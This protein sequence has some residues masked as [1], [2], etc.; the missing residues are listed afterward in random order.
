[1]S[2]WHFILSEPTSSAAVLATSSSSTTAAAANNNSSQGV[3]QRRTK[4]FRSNSTQ[5][6][7]ASEA[8]TTTTVA[9]IS[10]ASDTFYDPKKLKKFLY[11]PYLIYKCQICSRKMNSFNI[12]HWLQHDRENH[13]ALLNKESDK[14]FVYQQITVNPASVD[15]PADSTETQQGAES[16]TSASVTT[17]Q[18]TTYPS[19]TQFIEKFKQQTHQ[20]D[21][22]RL[23]NCLVCGHELHFTHADISKHY[24]SQHEINIF[25]ENLSLSL[26]D[27]DL[28]QQLTGAGATHQTPGTSSNQII[29]VWRGVHIRRRC[30][31]PSPISSSSLALTT[32]HRRSSTSSPTQAR[33]ELIDK[34]LRML[35]LIY[36]EQIVEKQI[37]SWLNSEQFFRRTYNYNSHVCIVC[38]ATRLSILNS[39]YQLSSQQQAAK[40]PKSASTN[41]VDSAAVANNRLQYFSDEMRTVVLTNHILG[42]FNEYCYRC[43]SC[44]ISWPDRNQLMRHTQ[45]CANSQLVRTKTK[46]KL[47]ANC[48]M[49][50]KFNIQSYMEYWLH[51]RYLESRKLSDQPSTE[52]RSLGTTFDMLTAAEVLEAD[53]NVKVYLKDVF[54]SKQLLLDLATKHGLTS[55]QHNDGDKSIKIGLED[56]TTGPVITTEATSQSSNSVSERARNEEV[57]DDVEMKDIEEDK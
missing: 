11:K 53:D 34:E 18:L 7:P 3:A 13:F 49:Q 47:K 39:H 12:E 27:L 56:E 6:A 4:R 36:R 52:I 19:F 5:P 26:A 24:Q 57:E 16:S 14:Q 46:Y 35:N 55:I 48:R 42:H 31:I 22:N 8:T 32:T 51:E 9:T 40:T 50:L 2:E 10:P 41:V 30:Y 1:M 28:L 44:K 20:G 54:K 15:T 29:Q 38:N 43:M 23:I 33:V 21:E 25:D 45:E 37:V 17:A